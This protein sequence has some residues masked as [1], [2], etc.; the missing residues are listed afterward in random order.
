M[1]PLDNL[2]GMQYRLDH[3]ENLKADA[4]DLIVH[5]PLKLKGDIEPFE[6]G[7]GAEISII[8][9]GD[10]E[11]MGKNLQGIFTAQNEIRELEARMEEYAGTPKQAMGVR[12]PGEKTAFEVQALENAAGRLFQEK[13]VNLEISLLEPLLNHMLGVGR[14]NFEGGVSVRSLD[15]KFGI[16]T[17][18]TIQPEDL[19][20][21]GM[22]RPIGARHFGERAQ[23][24]QNITQLFSG[25]IGPMLQPHWSALNTAKLIEDAMNLGRYNLVRKDIGLAEQAETQDTANTYNQLV[26]ERQQV[27]Q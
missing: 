6:W 12:T 2:I 9:D 14:D 8:D 26:A 1:G 19:A 10:V 13:V 25:P 16:D 21:N 24:V 15:D 3:L 11:E 7:P 23:L 5:P 18:L 17:F 27:P 4:M 22:V 20:A